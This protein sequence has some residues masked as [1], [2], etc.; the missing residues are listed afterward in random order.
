MKLEEP[1]VSLTACLSLKDFHFQCLQEQNLFD[2]DG[3]QSG[4]VPVD[5]DDVSEN[6]VAHELEQ[7]RQYARA[8]RG[9]TCGILVSTKLTRT[10]AISSELG[11]ELDELDVSESEGKNNLGD[12]TSARFNDPRKQDNDPRKQDRKR[13]TQAFATSPAKFAHHSPAPPKEDPQVRGFVS[14]LSLLPCSRPNNSS[15]VDPPSRSLT[16]LLTK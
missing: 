11:S 7:S 9:R 12:R 14:N 6:E 1:E 4:D 5:V 13:P 16:N 3:H 2:D 10:Q 15:R 8:V